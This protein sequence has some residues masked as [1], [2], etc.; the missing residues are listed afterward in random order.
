MRIRHAP[1]GLVLAVLS[2]LVA[3]APMNQARASKGTSA[4]IAFAR[5]YYNIHGDLFSEVYV[6]NADG[7]GR[8][9]LTRDFV[10]EGPLCGR[11]TDGR[12]PSAETEIST[13]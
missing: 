5:G 1:L 4:K 12:S 6:M 7:S 10:A 3:S 8:R 11:P 9:K 2:V 13:S